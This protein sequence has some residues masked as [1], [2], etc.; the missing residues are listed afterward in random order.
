MTKGVSRQNRDSD[1]RRPLLLVVEG[2]RHV[3]DMCAIEC[4]VEAREVVARR[5]R[6]LGCCSSQ[7]HQD[8]Y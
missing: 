7:M 2:F 8:A 3:V 5:Q 6:Y 4:S 1:R